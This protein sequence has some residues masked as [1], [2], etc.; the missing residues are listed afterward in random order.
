MLDLGFIWIIKVKVEVTS[1]EKLMGRSGGERQESI[2][3]RKKERERNRLAKF[4]V[5]RR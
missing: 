3:L 2:E 1:D 4:R 5:S